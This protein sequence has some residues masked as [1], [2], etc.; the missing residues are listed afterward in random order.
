MFLAPLNAA[1]EEFLINTP[2]R[3]AAWLSQVGHES[4]QLRYTEEIAS[5]ASYEGRHDLGNTQPGDG[6]LYKGRGLIMI[7]GRFGYADCAMELEIDCLVHPEILAEPVNACRTAAWWW[8]KHGCNELADKGDEI[9]L[10]K[11]INGGTNG[12]ADRQAL[13][14]VACKVLEVK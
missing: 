4:G 10:C 7:T 12:L 5:G 3:Q 8:K 2:I 6:K 13:Y 11:R 9:G 1:M 14:K